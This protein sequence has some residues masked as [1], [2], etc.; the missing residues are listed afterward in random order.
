MILYVIIIPYSPLL[1]KKNKRKSKVYLL[2][3]VG[4]EGNCRLLEKA[5][6][7]SYTL[8]RTGESFGAQRPTNLIGIK[9]PALCLCHHDTGEFWYNIR[10]DEHLF[11]NLRLPAQPCG[12]P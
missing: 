8:V 3:L 7:A 2:S 5:I 10:K 11:R 6:G 9:I 4:C 1:C 12:N